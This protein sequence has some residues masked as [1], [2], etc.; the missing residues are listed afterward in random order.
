MNRRRLAAAAVVA[1][2]ALGGCGMPG[3]TRVQDD[4]AGLA[5]GASGGS[6]TGNSPPGRLASV[7]PGQFVRNFL[8]APAGDIEN[9]AKRQREFMAT[10]AAQKWG[11][12]PEKGINVIRFTRDPQV[13]GEQVVLKG[14]QHIGVLTDFG[15]LDPPAQEQ[16]EY[17][18]KVGKNG[19]DNGLFI[20]QAPQVILMTANALEEYYE[21][22]A[23][24][25][26]DLEHA[27]LVPDVRYLPKSLPRVQR[28]NYLID[29]M[30]AGPSQ[31]LTKAVDPL[32][33]G[34]ARKGNVPDPGGGPLVVNLNAA[35]L[36]G[37][38][39]EVARLGSQL[40]WSLRLD[41]Q[42]D[43]D[44]RIDGQPEETFRGG[45][46]LADNPVVRSELP[47]Q[48][49][50]VF[51]GSV[52]GRDVGEGPPS[53]PIGV[54]FNRDV[55]SA[56]LARGR[57]TDLVGALVRSTT[58]GRLRLWVGEGNQYTA[59]G[60]S[61]AEMS[62]PT[63]LPAVALAGLGEVGLV[64]ADGRLYQFRR[65]SPDLAAVALTGSAGRTTAVAAPPDG[66]R[67][68]YVRGGRLYVAAFAG[69][70]KLDLPVEVPSPLR[71]VSAVAWSGQDRLVIAGR[72]AD[73]ATGLVDVSV[74]GGY[75]GKEVPLP[76]GVGQL[77][78]YPEKPNTADEDRRV[79]YQLQ[80]GVSYELFDVRPFEI[81]AAEVDPEAQNSPIHPT[82]PFF[83]E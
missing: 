42:G 7:D 11:P 1:T 12:Q 21:P 2:V 72:R 15:R 53:V 73:G 26:W 14:V 25:F 57:K 36:E 64:V 47:A 35:A 63:W 9:A 31:W 82:A 45:N 33:E 83:L 49:F 20:L 18:F 78:A 66:R 48:A 67:I 39:G 50:C 77:V 38:E 44:L 32:P 4:G 40:R 34:I 30:M 61:F 65:G 17:W 60:G 16:T 19:Q 55:R 10:G 68:A 80:N 5:G 81:K 8:A 59:V 75:L 28:P 24:Y 76:A 51:Q 54:A 13:K 41:W 37:E 69:P 43:L 79:M 56:A 23:L 58:N 3:Q 71:A 74:D 22:R 29:G 46:Y 27:G 6:E 52:R 62:R 70:S